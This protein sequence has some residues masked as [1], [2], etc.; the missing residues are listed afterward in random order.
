MAFKEA[1]ASSYVILP[2]DILLLHNPWSRSVV[3]RA[4]KPSE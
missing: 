2:P 3:Y 1:N 4:L